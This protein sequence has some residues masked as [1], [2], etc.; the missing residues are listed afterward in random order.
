MK[1]EKV[2]F[3]IIRYLKIVKM[4]YERIFFFLGN[5]KKWEKKE[6]KDIKKNLMNE[7]IYY[8][9]WGIKYE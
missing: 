1:L 3:F 9:G 5:E 4:W 8:D 7:F 2:Y 6:R